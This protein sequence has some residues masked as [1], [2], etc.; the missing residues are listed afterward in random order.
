MPNADEP[1]SLV[2]G[3][4]LNLVT[5]GLH[6]NPLTIYREYIQNAADSIVSA[7]DTV[8]GKVKI[9]I[10]VSGLRVKIRDN[11]PGLS[12]KASVR[13]LLP[14]ALSQKRRETDRGFRG[15]GRLS[16]LAF[17]ESV[18]FLTRAESDCPVTRIVWNGPK[19]RKRILETGEIERAIRECVRVE[20]VAGLD[21][22]AHF[23]EVEIGGVGR[24]AAGLILN[25]EAVRTYIG[26]VCPV[27]MSPTFPFASNIENLFGENEPPLALEIIFDGELTPI[28]RRYGKMI[29]FSQDREDCFTEFE[30][31]DIPSA[32][33]N[34]NAAV[35]WVAHSSYLGAIPKE[36]GIRGVRARAGNIQIGSEAVFDR[37][38]QD[39]RFNRWCVGEIHIVD[40][41]I[42][43][44][45]R[46]DYFE[47]GPHTRNL[48][49]QLGAVI[50]R[51]VTRCRKA[52]AT[53]NKERKFLSTLHRM[54]ETYDLAVSGYLLP[55][56]AKAMI[57][58]ALNRLRDIRE[59]SRDPKN[60]H[61]EVDLEKLDEVEMKL[62]NFK[63]RRSRP[64]FR[65]ITA[66]ET[67]TYRKVF[68]TLAEVSQSPHA[69]KE[70]IEAIL[71]HTHE[72][73][74]SNLAAPSSRTFRSKR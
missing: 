30:E 60:G 34:E 55:K 50:H 52:S 32:N 19:L 23:F 43:P 41:R 61:T 73:G 40:P 14:I 47:P 20:T 66:S 3:D 16:G 38:F 37:L 21:Y 15:I 12:H 22:P 35:G 39:E 11:G 74:S 8:N 49:N 26:E 33:R 48:E 2:G 70:M 42:V 36:T 28:T 72:I 45:G 27:P 31:I 10:D 53:R 63:A 54:E 5:A 25:R 51:I 46:R 69:A 56:D 29:Q 71:L 6:D 67:T 58:Q 57:R 62:G 68:Q 24:H 7:G 64:M 59:E 9:D 44:N 1:E 4:I 18:T 17:A 13:A 65:N